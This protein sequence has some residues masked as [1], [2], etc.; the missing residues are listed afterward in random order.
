[1]SSKKQSG[2]E[3]PCS[4]TTHTQREAILLSAVDVQTQRGVKCSLVGLLGEKNWDEECVQSQWGGAEGLRVYR[5]LAC[6][7][8][9]WT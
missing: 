9:I 1:M 4:A 2:V 7:E 3:T 5:G 8:K 6:K